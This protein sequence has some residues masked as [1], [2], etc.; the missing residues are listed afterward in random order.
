[1]GRRLDSSLRTLPGRTPRC[2]F[3]LRWSCHATEIGRDWGNNSEQW[4][5]DAAVALLDTVIY[6]RPFRRADLETLYKIDQVCFAPGIAYSKAELR[7]YLQHSKSFTVVAEATSV[8]ESNDLNI[9][10]P[11]IAGFCTGQLYLHEGVRLGHI[12]T[13]DVL[14][15]ARRQ[16]AGRLLLTAVEE[17]FRAN[18]VKSIRLE[19][20][21]DNLP[22]Q[23]FYH[24][25]GYETIGRIP[26]YY[27][28]RFDALMMEK[29][30]TGDA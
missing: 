30:L 5:R 24:A 19:V 26:G 27:L 16:R 23:N 22:A 12:I 25:M 10:G 9:A 4:Q 15:E 3:A 28:G 20:A 6:L 2:G 21:V 1:V 11:N 8:A 29:Q 7:Y 17:H 18:D 13:I 14:P